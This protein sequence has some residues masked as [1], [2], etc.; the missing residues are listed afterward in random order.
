MN[1]AT[2]W[3]ERNLAYQFKDA[4][5]LQQ[6]LTHRSAGGAHNERLE[7]LGDAILGAVIARC[8]FDIRPTASEGALSRYRALLVRRDSLAE[9]ARELGVGEQLLMGGGE[10][11]SGGRQRS[12]T[13]ADALEAV[14]GAVYLD[15]GFAAAEELIR[16]LYA[17]RLAGLPPEQALR[18]AKTALQEV[19]QARGLALPGYA[20]LKASGPPHA[21]R[22][23]VACEI[24]ALGIRT[25]AS[26]SSRRKAE[27][28]AAALALAQ[29]EDAG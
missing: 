21:Q 13:L 2:H 19:L 29:L 18:D 28:S 8:L 7:F 1:S 11:G 15:G 4:T 22:F 3:A 9:L 27:Q 6:A 23:E 20:L 12:S 5:L 25:V 24:P 10:L 26:G 16:R 14:L 17:S